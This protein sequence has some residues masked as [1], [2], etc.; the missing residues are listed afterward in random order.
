VEVD[1][2]LI[3]QT[4]LVAAL[5]LVSTV[6]AAWRLTP[7]RTRYRILSSLKP[8]AGS[9]LGR[10]VIGLKNKAGNE[11]SHGCG[12]CAGSPTKKPSIAGRPRG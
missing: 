2:E 1:V 11:L 8:N 4:L 7:A 12:A 5:V 10:W 3:F 9:A 6:F